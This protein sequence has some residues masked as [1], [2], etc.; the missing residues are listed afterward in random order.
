MKNIF[1]FNGFV[2][3]KLKKKNEAQREIRR[4]KKKSHFHRSVVFSFFNLITRPILY[5]CLFFLDPLSFSFS[6]VPDRNRFRPW[7]RKSART[8]ITRTD[9]ICFPLHCNSPADFQ[10]L[11]LHLFILSGNVYFLPLPISVLT[12]SR[13]LSSLLRER[14]LHG[15]R[16][17][18]HET[19]IHYSKTKIKNRDTT[20]MVY[21]VGPVKILSSLF[22]HNPS[23][24]QLGKK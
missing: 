1:H 5:F 24:L 8:G 13:S 3:L 2:T 19:I 17:M 6:N 4:E 23:H 7:T 20:A 21:K 18:K 16:C 11:R 12:Q 22:V 9:S 10:S 14:P 15:V